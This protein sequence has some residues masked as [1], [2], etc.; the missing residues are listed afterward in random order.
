MDAEQLE[1]LRKIQE[2]FRNNQIDY[3]QDNVFQQRTEKKFEQKTEERFEQR[4]EEE[5]EKVESVANVVHEEQNFY[6]SV[7]EIL[8]RQK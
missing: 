2:A 8:K 4:F 1:E 5:T 3:G 7:S 6:Y